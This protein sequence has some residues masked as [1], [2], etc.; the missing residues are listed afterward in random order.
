MNIRTRKEGTYYARS[1][2]ARRA[3]QRAYYAKNKETM[4]RA[5]ELERELDPEAYALRLKICRDRKAMHKAE[6]AKE[7]S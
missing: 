4:K 3:Y 2:E 5:R 7:D 6:K 1:M